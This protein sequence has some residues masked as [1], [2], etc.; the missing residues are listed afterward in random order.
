MTKGGLGAL[1]NPWLPNM[2]LGLDLLFF[3]PPWLLY[4]LFSKGICVPLPS[5][6]TSLCFILCLRA[7]KKCTRAR[8]EIFGIPLLQ[9]MNVFKYFLLLNLNFRSYLMD[10]T[11]ISHYFYVFFLSTGG[12]VYLYDQ[13][14][15]LAS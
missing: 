2:H 11:N 14:A 7:F 5:C 3:S 6:A 8:K 12:P 1:S 9:T 15:L 10:V 13:N 4:R